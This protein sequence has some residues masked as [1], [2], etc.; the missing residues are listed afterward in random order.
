MN[1]LSGRES[2]HGRVCRDGFRRAPDTSLK[3]V[4]ICV[5]VEFAAKSRELEGSRAEREAGISDMATDLLVRAE[6]RQV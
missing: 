1:S 5:A 3:P 4:T 6:G 2:S